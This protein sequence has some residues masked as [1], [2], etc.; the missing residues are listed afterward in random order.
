MTYL[1]AIVRMDKGVTPTLEPVQMAAVQVMKAP[2]VTIRAVKICTGKVVACS[3]EIAGIAQLVKPLM[4]FVPQVALVA[5]ESP[6]VSVRQTTLV[7]TAL[8]V[9]SVQMQKNVM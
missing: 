1:V 7:Q 9:D 2:S 6:C 3:V 5:T 4:E 8:S